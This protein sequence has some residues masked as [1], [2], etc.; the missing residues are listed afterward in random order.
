MAKFQ[1]GIADATRLAVFDDVVRANQMSGG[2]IFYV[3][4][5]SDVNYA[6]CVARYGKRR[7]FST[8][9]EA[10]GN[11][12]SNRNDI[13]F[14]SGYASHSTAMLS[15]SK[16]R[17]HFIGMNSFGR[18]NSQCSK[19]STP[20]T[21]VAAS[22][23]VINNSGTRNSFIGLKIIQQG[24]NVAQ[25]S[26]LIDTGE[27]TYV[28]DCEMEVNSI[29]STA[30]QGVLFKGDTCH[31]KNCQIGNATVYHTAENQAPLV[32]QTPARYSYFEDCTIINYTS[33]TSASLIDAP[34]TDS[35]I[36]F[37]MFK[38]V[39][40]ICATLGNGATAGGTIAEAV[41]NAGTS[42]Y[43]LFDN[44]CTCYG[45]GIFAETVAYSLNAAAA[46]ATT[47]GGGE[48]VAGA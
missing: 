24:T 34:D 4:E 16:S 3:V 27:G 31:Y 20:A 35:L 40:L 14:I 1:E 6:Q 26:G 30:T 8:V 22:V 42:G 32:I 25:T 39:S 43:L 21:D 48:A 37:I 29:L 38:N 2:E 18:I 47:A 11:V 28:K 41:T 36:G 7:V 9:A 17:V 13:I 12:V 15:V 33:Q 10:Y 46:G 19:I 44:R 45:C 5:D 23:A